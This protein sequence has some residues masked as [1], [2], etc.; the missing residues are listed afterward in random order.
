[1]PKVN[2]VSRGT[3]HSSRAKCGNKRFVVRTEMEKKEKEHCLLQADLALQKTHAIAPEALLSNAIQSESPHILFY[4]ISAPSKI[5][6]LT[7]S[8]RDSL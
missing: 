6:N 2:G 7:Q 4:D 3:R 1:M 8:T 5:R